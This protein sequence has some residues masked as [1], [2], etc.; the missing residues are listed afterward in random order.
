MSFAAAGDVETV[1]RLRPPAKDRLGQQAGP[2]APTDMPGCLFEPR[3]STEN[4]DGANQTDSS[5]T[6]Y[7]PAGSPAVVST[8]QMRIR[9][10]VY[11]VVGEPDDWGAEGVVIQVHRVKG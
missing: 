6:V 11:N 2:P 3:G 9:G 5:G 7:A 10:A 1:V 8:D 4:R